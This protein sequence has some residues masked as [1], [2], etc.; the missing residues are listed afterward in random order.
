M[1]RTDDQRERRTFE[2]RRESLMRKVGELNDLTTA[3][4]VLIGIDR[5]RTFSFEPESGLLDRFG[6]NL[7]ICD[8]FG[9]DDITKSRKH[10][11]SLST[12]SDSTC[13]D[14]SSDS[15][16]ESPRSANGLRSAV[17]PAKTRACIKRT[18]VGPGKKA[19][20]AIQRL[21]ERDVSLLDVEFFRA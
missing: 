7:A 15:S 17:L 18:R 3:Q 20:K 2:T 10:S 12:T 19:L 13:T 11:G 9:P 5:G 14:H 6:V 21:L 16:S 8:R 1:A 4:V